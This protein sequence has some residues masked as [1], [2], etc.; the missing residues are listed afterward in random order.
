MQCEVHPHGDTLWILPEGEVDLESSRLM[1]GRLRECVEAGFPRLVLDLRDVTFLDSSGLRTIIDAGRYAQSRNVRFA[2]AP[3]PPAV[4]RI[5]DITGTA[6]LF[7][8]PATR[9]A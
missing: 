9:L 4:K 6:D 2:V 3:G 1:R 8:V 5:F 7:P